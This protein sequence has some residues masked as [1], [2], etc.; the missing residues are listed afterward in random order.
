MRARRGF[1]LW[2]MTIVFAIMAVTALIVAPQWLRLGEAPAAATGQPIL[3]ALRDA[4]RLAITAHQVVALRIDPSSGRYRVD[5]SGV[6]GTGVYFE[7]E[8]ALGALESMESDQARVQYIF[9]PTG[10]TSSDTLIVRS[11]NG[12][13]LIAVDPWSG[14]AT[15]YAR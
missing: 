6:A 7:G 10:A 15:S 8:L 5:T 3:D 14:V 1:T 2:E 13:V 12:S 9:R 4:R 11:A